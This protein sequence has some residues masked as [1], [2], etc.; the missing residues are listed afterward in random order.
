[1]AIRICDERDQPPKAIYRHNLI[2]DRAVGAYEIRRF[3]SN[4]CS[5]SD[6]R[7]RD[8]RRTKMARNRAGERD[9]SEEENEEENATELP[10][11][12]LDQS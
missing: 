7:D 1:M 5:H 2:T 12:F 6:L 9:A 3:R 11:P 4:M 8:T 10:L